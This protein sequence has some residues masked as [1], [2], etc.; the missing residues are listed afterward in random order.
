MP[1]GPVAELAVGANRPLESTC[2]RHSTTSSATL[3]D[4]GFEQCSDLG[5]L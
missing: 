1:S 4:H 3:F 2:S 5:R